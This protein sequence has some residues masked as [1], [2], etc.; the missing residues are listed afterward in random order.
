MKSKK[1][2]FYINGISHNRRIWLLVSFKREPSCNLFVSLKLNKLFIC[3]SIAHGT[4]SQ[5]QEMHATFMLSRF[6][7]SSKTF[8]A[9]FL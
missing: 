8:A 2:F 5:I 9:V 4:K 3:N 1:L 7:L 6:S